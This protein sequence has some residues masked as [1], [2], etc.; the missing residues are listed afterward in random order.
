MILL[1]GIAL[2]ACYNDLPADESSDSQDTRETINQDNGADETISEHDTTED[3]TFTQNS[4]NETTPEEVAGKVETNEPETTPFVPSIELEITELSLREAILEINESQQIDVSALYFTETLGSRKIYENSLPEI[5]GFEYPYVYYERMSAIVKD[6][7]PE[8][9]ALYVG[10]YSVETKEIQ[11]FA[12]E[13]FTAISDEAR[14]VINNDYVVYMYTTFGEQ[15]MMI[16]ELF[17]FAESTRQILDETPAHNVFGYVKNL[18]ESEIVLFMYE[19]TSAG[20]QQKITR[21]NLITHELSEIYRGEIMGGYKDSQTSTKDIFAIDTYND[22][23]YLLMHQYSGNR[24]HSFIQKLDKNG[25]MLSEEK[26]DSLSQYSTLEDTADSLVILDNYAIIHYSQFNKSNS[27]TNPPAA[28]LYHTYDGYELLNVGGKINIHTCCGSVI[29]EHLMAIFN[30]RNDNDTIFACNAQTN[31]GVSINIS[32][33]SVVASCVDSKGYLLVETRETERSN[34]YVV[35]SS[36]FLG[37][38]KN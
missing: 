34:W 16:T 36:L 33:S 2:S 32:C 29:T 8:A 6:A 21:Y 18:N 25:N 11:E 14:M 4:I 5:I 7:S 37:L 28:V 20:A 17:N 26:I 13:Q 23:I 27:N 31:E 10:R 9:P 38:V 12:I 35:P 24:M 30:I 15:L 19:A 1:I 3:T 22:E